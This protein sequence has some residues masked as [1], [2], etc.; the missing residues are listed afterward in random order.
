MYF[1]AGPECTDGDIRLTI[2]GVPQNSS[3]Q[4]E[5]CQLQVWGAVC[6]DEWD[7]RD[8]TVF[9][10]QLGYECKLFLLLYINNTNMSTL[11]W[12]SYSWTS[13]EKVLV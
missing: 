5:V 3:G 8:A 6:D 10:R 9:C 11:F 4:V 2:G 12:C 7:A 13:S 1:S